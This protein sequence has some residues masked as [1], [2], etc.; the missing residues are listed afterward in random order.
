M[1]IFRT[2][3]LAAFSIALAMAAPR[4]RLSDTTVGPVAIAAGSNGPSRAIEFTNAGDGTLNVTVRSSVTW[5]VPAIG[6]GRPCGILGGGTCTPINIALNTAS[7]SAGTY[8]GII[9]VTDPNAVDA[10]QT[11]A[12]TVAIGGAV[13]G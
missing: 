1:K 6:A 12:V 7:L 3:I 4:L 10:P 5:A 9:T 8:T 13:A 2:L 11:I